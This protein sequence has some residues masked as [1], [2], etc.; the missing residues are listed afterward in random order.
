MLGR[1]SCTDIVYHLD[2]AVTRDIQQ[3]NSQSRSFMFYSCTQRTIVQI[4]SR[5]KATR[6][7][8]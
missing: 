3:P 7:L 5:Y 8:C 2:V 4:T 6:L 1:K